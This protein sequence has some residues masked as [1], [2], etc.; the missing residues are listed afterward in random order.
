LAPVT[1]DARR[2]GETRAFTTKRVRSKLKHLNPIISSR[3][4]LFYRAKKLLDDDD[5]HRIVSVLNFVVRRPA[6]GVVT[7]GR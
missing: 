1:I 3:F 6:D 5:M 2:G 7:D 4:I